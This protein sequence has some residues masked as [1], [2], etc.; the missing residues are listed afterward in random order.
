MTGTSLDALDGAAVRLE[1]S[2]LGLRAREVAAPVSLDSPGDLR[3]TLGALSSGEAAPISLATRAARELGEL[4]A[5]AARALIAR[6]GKPDLA[7]AHGQTVF[8]APP[9]SCQLFNPWPLAREAR[10]RVVFD[11]RGA[12]L[13]Q[14]GQGAPITP[15]ADW[16]LFPAHRASRA[17]VNLGGFCN[18]TLLP[19]GTGGFTPDS[20]R[21]MDVCACNHLLNAAARLA[22]GQPFD[23]DGAA[24]A[25]AS[26]HEPIAAALRGAL[27]RQRAA[28]RSLG[29]GDEA[30]ATLEALARAHRPAP[31]SL[32]A[33]AVHAV[34]GCVAGAIRSMSPAPGRVLLAGGS[35]RN[36]ALVGELRRLLAPIRV[37]PT[38]AL[39]VPAGYREAAA[40]AALGAM[41]RRR[42]DH[43]AFR[44]RREGRRADLWAWI[45][46]SRVMT[47][48]RANPPD[49]SRV[50]TE[51]RNERSRRSTPSRSPSACA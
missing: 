32:L 16:A 38:D 15:V 3:R 40:F 10:C 42:A 6:A 5:L 14:G 30:V 31:A 13:A 27:E 23:R 1:G 2:A 24:A 26:P 48:Q 41:C 43:A 22:L 45:D 21:G 36:A 7:C 20:V 35:V 17:V 29:S 34:A 12:D 47:D 50:S 49:R 8:H 33:S 4:H 9:D 11:L 25:S 18:I 44:Y 19:A 39:G 51:R 37:D 46:P 28:G